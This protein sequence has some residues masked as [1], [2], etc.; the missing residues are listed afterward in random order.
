[1]VHTRNKLFE[2]NSLARLAVV[3]RDAFDAI[4]MHDL[5]GRIQAWNPAAVRMYGWS[6]AEALQMNIVQRIPESQR[7]AYLKK[8]HQLNQAEILQPY[9]TQRLTKSGA[10]VDV[11]VTSTA[12]INETGRIYA[13]ATTERPKEFMPEGAMN[14]HQYR[15]E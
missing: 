13:I 5:D 9:V 4:T 3:L 2:A 8:L 14:E 10:A 11:F 1:M 15:P 7:A 12:L 6:E